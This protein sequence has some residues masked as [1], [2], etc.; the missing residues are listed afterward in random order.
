MAFP[1]ESHS[2]GGR[3]V[4]VL[5]PLVQQ[6]KREDHH[7]ES[8][9]NPDGFFGATRDESHQDQ[10]RQDEEPEEEDDPEPFAEPFAPRHF[11]RLF[12]DI[13]PYVGATSLTHSIQRAVDNSII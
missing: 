10:A 7:H 5:A 2:G 8:G 9:D 4:P 3:E 13:F 12:H 1:K 6:E 11:H